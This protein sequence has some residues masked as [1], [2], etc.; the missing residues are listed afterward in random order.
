MYLAQKK[1]ISQEIQ[2]HSKLHLAQTQLLIFQRPHFNPEMYVYSREQKA[3]F[4]HSMKKAYTGRQQEIEITF[5][6]SE[7]EIKINRQHENEC[8]G[9]QDCLYS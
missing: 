3:P 6:V 4:I 2:S 9:Q 7:C 5:D 8:P 1:S